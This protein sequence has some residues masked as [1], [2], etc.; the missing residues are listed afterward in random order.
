MSNLNTENQPNDYNKIPV[1]YC[2]QC[3]SLKIRNISIIE[4][5]EYCDECGSTNI[6]KCSIEEWE[7]LYK[8]RYGH[9]FLENY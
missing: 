9:K 1:L 8:N 6:G 3:L 4:D 2:K 7:M 5:S